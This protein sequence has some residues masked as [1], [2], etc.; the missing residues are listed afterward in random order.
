MQVWSPCWPDDPRFARIILAAISLP[1]PASSRMGMTPA[2]IWWLRLDDAGDA[3]I[4]AG[5]VFD[6]GAIPAGRAVAAPSVA[7]T[8]DGELLLAYYLNVENGSWDLYLARLTFDEA[9]RPRAA[10]EPPRRLAGDCRPFVPA[11]FSSDG[12]WVSAVQLDRDGRGMVLRLD[13]A[14]DET[15]D[16]PPA[17]ALRPAAEKWGPMATLVR[18]CWRRAWRSRRARRSL[19]GPGCVPP[20]QPARCGR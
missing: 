5:P 12:R 3:I 2:R 15:P 16:P 7:T 4:D 18:C 6:P 1:P 13:L 9:G 19:D 14:A 10:P 11:A 8:A 20:H 17:A